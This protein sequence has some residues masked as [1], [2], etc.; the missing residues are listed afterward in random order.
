[1]RRS[2]FLPLS[3][4][5]LLALSGCAAGLQPP[6]GGAGAVA[7][8]AAVEQFLQAARGRDY[9]GMGWLFGTDAGSVMRRDPVGDVERRMYAIA[10]VLEHE[11]HELRERSPVA[12]RS[13]G[14]WHLPVVLH[15]SGRTSNVPFVVVRGP[16]N[17][18]FVENVDLQAVTGPGRR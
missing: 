5:L 12:G 13:G 16:Q 17:R 11:R 6:A 9:Q 10:T 4:L 15:Q 3:A 8:E 7:P 14:A 1:M 2:Y 18:W